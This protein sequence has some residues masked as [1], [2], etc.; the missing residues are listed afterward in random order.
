VLV[1]PLDIAAYL[2]A[3]RIDVGTTR[4]MIDEL[5][6]LDTV[7]NR[8]AEVAADLTVMGAYAHSGERPS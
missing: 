5:A 2:H 6:V 1:P 7:L 3:H 4:V 8:A